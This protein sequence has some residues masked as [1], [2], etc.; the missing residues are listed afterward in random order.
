MAYIKFEIKETVGVVAES[1]K[2]RK[3]QLNLIS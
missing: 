2:R 3:K 1:T